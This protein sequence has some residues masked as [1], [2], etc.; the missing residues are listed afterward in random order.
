[1]SLAQ[2]MM[3]DYQVIRSSDKAALTPWETRDIHRVQRAW[4]SNEVTK[5]FSGKTVVVTHHLP[6]PLS[7]HEKYRGDALNPC[8]ASDLSALVRAPVDLWVHGHTHESMD[9]EI[10]GTRVVC[11][12]RG[13]LP[14]DPNHNFEPGLLVEI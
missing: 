12:P 7:I 1:M 10:S 8:F 11:N 13:Y 4:L 5:P 14:E 3:S 6:L 9:Y 2:S